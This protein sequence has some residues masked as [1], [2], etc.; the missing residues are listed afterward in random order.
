MG[1]MV[2]DIRLAIE[3]RR[4]VAL[5][6]RAGGIIPSSEEVYKRIMEIAENGGADK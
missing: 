3:C 1:Q 2:D 6:N 4:P 5:C